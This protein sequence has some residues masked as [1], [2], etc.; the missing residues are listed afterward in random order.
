MVVVC[1]S[2]VVVLS[3]VVRLLSCLLPLFSFCLIV[4]ELLR[5]SVVLPAGLRQLSRLPLLFPDC[6]TV[7]LEVVV[8]LGLGYIVVGTGGRL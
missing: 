4:V 7:V 3:R 2:F 8:L 6:L 5:R 1:S